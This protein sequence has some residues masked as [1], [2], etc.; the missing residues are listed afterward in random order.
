MRAI[1]Y[2]SGGD[3]GLMNKIISTSWGEIQLTQVDRSRL[4]S[5]SWRHTDGLGE[6]DRMAV[7][8]EILFSCAQTGEVNR[9]PLPNHICEALESDEVLRWLES[10][11]RRAN[12]QN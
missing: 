2:D 10:V 7:P 8:G 12:S 6:A 5:V 11:H 4:I 9:V 3:W 1:F